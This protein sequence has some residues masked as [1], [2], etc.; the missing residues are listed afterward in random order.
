MA[1]TSSKSRPSAGSGA[2]RPPTAS[3]WPKPSPPTPCG[4]SPGER[5][6]GFRRP[7]RDW[8]ARFP[9]SFG[10]HL[11]LEELTVS[12]R[13]QFPGRH[14][15]SARLFR[16]FESPGAAEA[17]ISVLLLDA[18]RRSP[19]CPWPCVRTCRASGRTRSALRISRSGRRCAGRLVRKQATGMLF[20]FGPGGP[21][22]AS[23]LA[24]N[25]AIGPCRGQPQPAGELHLRAL[26][27]APR[28]PGL[29]AG[30]CRGVAL[31]LDRGGAGLALCGFAGMG[32]STL[33]LHLAARGLDFL[34]NDRVLIEPAS[35]G[36][37]PVLHGIPKH[38]RLN[39]GTALGNP[40]LAPFLSPRS[41]PVAA[42]G[43]RESS[44]PGLVR[45]R[46]QV[47]RHHRRVLQRP[48]H[49]R[50]RAG[51][52]PPVRA[53]GRLGRAQLEARRRPHGGA[54]G[55]VRRTA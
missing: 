32:K 17:D 28:G 55:G 12:V 2:S 3:T 4:S 23:G 33:A 46:G 54:A 18:P 51:A 48:Q 45:H 41:A 42:R 30:P 37:G 35:P 8:T 20:L 39:P 16:P 34:S 9:A 52:L 29:A 11:R 31:P 5:R 26:H 1:P 24:R 19:R 7:G 43:L 47:R 50:G 53:P 38:P 22:N 49:R 14:G 10:F 25:I 44:A 36:R 13:G 21:A 40:E 27:G 6:P 15:R